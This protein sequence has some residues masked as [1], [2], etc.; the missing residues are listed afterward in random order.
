VSDRSA[1]G[2][3]DVS[4]F[5]ESFLS[6]LEDLAAS[7]DRV[8][9][10]PRAIS[11]SLHDRLI[12]FLAP[13]PGRD[14]PLSEFDFVCLAQVALSERTNA[15]IETCRQS[16][17]GEAARAIESF[18]VFFQALLPTAREPGLMEIKRLFYRLVP[19]LLQIAFNDFASSESGRRDGLEALRS[20]ERVLGEISSLP[21][22][23]SESELV[24]RSID[25]MTSLVSV[26]EY[27]MASEVVSSQLLS[28]IARNKLTRALY[29]IMQVEVGIQVYL[30]ERLGYLTP[31]ICLPDDLARLSDYG[32]V[33]L[34]EEDCA[35]GRVRRFIQVHLPDM[36]NLNDVV[37]HLVDQAN[38]TAHTQRLDA[39]GSAELTVPDA[40]YSLG[41]VYEPQA[42]PA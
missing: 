4:F 38:G 20:L 23:P 14:E 15:L 28:I 10:A 26:G 42:P 21:L 31:Q 41:L 13:A 7:T 3:F 2:D 36:G 5:D 6:E 37:L 17:R 1:Q 8:A 22:T 27:A 40:S 16:G 30:R 39:L 18:I 29:Q 34:F 12:A 11:D 25:Q 32:P 33:Q 35:D 19:T 9:A 24:F